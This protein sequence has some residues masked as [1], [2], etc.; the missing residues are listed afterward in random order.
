[1]SRN[2]KKS[3]VYITPKKIE[4]NQ[5]MIQRCKINFHPTGTA[6]LSPQ[7][8]KGKNYSSFKTD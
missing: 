4:R 2:N 3:Y 6:I 8:N 5:I 1:M 7:G